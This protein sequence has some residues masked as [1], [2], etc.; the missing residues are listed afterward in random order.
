MHV[1][2]ISASSY[3]NTAPLVW[4]FLFG[5]NH[6]KV[7]I[8]LDT[9]PSRSAQL[10]CEDRVDAALVPVIAYQMLDGVSLVPEVCVG[11]RARVRSV[12]L[13]TNGIDLKDV[14]SVALDTSSLT[15]ANLSKIIFREFV[16]L[17]PVWVE[18]EPDLGKMLRGFD[19]ALLIGEPSL[20]IDENIYR[21]FD[22]VEVWRSFTGL[23]FVFAMWMTKRSHYTIDFVEARNEGLAH[24]DDIVANYETDLR[25]KP[26][27]LKTYLSEN[28]SYSIDQTMQKGLD[29]YFRLA[30]KH[31][32]IAENKP[33][34]FLDQNKPD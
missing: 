14:R 8:I 23:G 24:I 29:E 1:Q 31:G 7:E 22:L 10:L 21:K 26:E 19:C 17:D 6:G 12:C 5:Q 18:H 16:G 11:A 28:I 30:A 4:S 25:L 13:V 15:S 34:R 32:L 33:L 3:S 20:T 27:D 9:A 2:R